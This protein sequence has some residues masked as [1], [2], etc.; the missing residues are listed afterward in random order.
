VG[1]PVSE[2]RRGIGYALTAYILWG[3]LPLY[4][5]A[6]DPAVP[7]EILGWRILFSL[8]FCLILIA[9]TSQLASTFRLLRIPRTLWLSVCAGILIGINWGVFIYATQ[10]DAILDAALGYFMNPLVTAALG[11]V[12]LKERLRPLQ[13]TALGLGVVAVAAFAVGFGSIPAIS[14]VL[15]FSFGTYGMVKKLMGRVGALE[16]LTLETVWLTPI[17]VALIVWLWLGGGLTLWTEGPGHALFFGFIGVATTIPLLL[18]AGATR[19]IPLSTVGLLQYV[20]PIMQALIGVLIMSEPM[21]LGRL[22]GFAIVWLALITF[23]VDAWKYRKEGPDSPREVR[24]TS[25]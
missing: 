25:S 6:L 7:L 22:V 5:I 3:F 21:P 23:S 19:R 10:N 18:F 8:V 4:F 16:G 13:W 24:N 17:A 12:V 20:N 15:A 9:G 1:A 11:V 2:H 14:L